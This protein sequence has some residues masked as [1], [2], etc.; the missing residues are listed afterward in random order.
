MNSLAFP[1]PFSR[2]SCQEVG[3]FIL[4]KFEILILIFISLM[5]W[6]GQGIDTICL[7]LN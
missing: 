6:D 2:A 5:E 4:N 7:T 1:L 3:K